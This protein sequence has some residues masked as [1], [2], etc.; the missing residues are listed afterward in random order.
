ML[1]YCSDS[2]EQKTSTRI[3]AEVTFRTTEESKEVHFA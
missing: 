2:S 1:H 3:A